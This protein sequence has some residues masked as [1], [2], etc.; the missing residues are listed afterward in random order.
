[1]ISQSA[2]FLPLLSSP[3]SQHSSPFSQLI[4]YSVFS[5]HLLFSTSLLLHFQVFVCMGWCYYLSMCYF[6]LGSNHSHTLGHHYQAPQ[7][8]SSIGKGICKNRILS[9]DADRR[10]RQCDHSSDQFHSSDANWR[11]RGCGHGSDQFHSND[12]DWRR[13]RCGHKINSSDHSTAATLTGLEDSVTTAA[14]ISTAAMLTDVEEM[15]L[16]TD[17][18][19]QQIKP[20]WQLWL[21]I[22]PNYCCGIYFLGSEVLHQAGWWEECDVDLF[23]FKLLAKPFHHS[24]TEPDFNLIIILFSTIYFYLEHIP[25]C[26]IGTKPCFIPTFVW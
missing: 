7:W 26:W 1:M 2:S 5:S 9:S 21:T 4:F 3:C 6:T 24:S 17:W 16:A 19:K 20:N 10:R 14:T 12:A 18:K 13:R 11:W 8:C 22:W 15:C 23:E 25:C